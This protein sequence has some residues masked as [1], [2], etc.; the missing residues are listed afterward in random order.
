MTPPRFSV[1]RYA[2]PA[3]DTET[4]DVFRYFA[5]LWRMRASTAR[6][7]AAKEGVSDAY[8]TYLLTHANTADAAAQQWEARAL[9]CQE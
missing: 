2:E 8:V 6:L 4:P 7:Q 9:S 1:P 3:P 5:R